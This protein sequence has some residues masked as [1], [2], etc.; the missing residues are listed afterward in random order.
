MILGRHKWAVAL[1][2][3]PDS[4]LHRRT[5]MPAVKNEKERGRTKKFSRLLKWKS[6]ETAGIVSGNRCHFREWHSYRAFSPRSPARGARRPRAYRGAGRGARA[7]LYVSYSEMFMRPVQRP[8]TKMTIKINYSH[9]AAIATAC[10]P[11]ITPASSMAA[12]TWRGN[13]RRYES[14]YVN[15]RESARLA[16][17]PLTMGKFA[18]PDTRHW[19][20]N[21]THY[22]CTC[23]LEI[24]QLK[25][26]FENISRE[27]IEKFANR[28]WG[29]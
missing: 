3:V 29:L 13:S 5:T 7:T 17:G 10:R 18:P 6:T 22:G 28:I 2:I 27:F 23:E 8:I 16:P 26:C 11:P 1:P 15:N 25:P 24:S 4:P 19:P 12:N 9:H 21:R 20:L 14:I